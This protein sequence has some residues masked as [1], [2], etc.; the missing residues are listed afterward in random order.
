MR[1][2]LSA[3]LVRSALGAAGFFAV[4][5]NF[6]VAATSLEADQ[7]DKLQVNESDTN[8]RQ[9]FEITGIV[10]D[11]ALGIKRVEQH[12]TGDVL[13]ITASL[14]LANSRHTGGLHYNVCPEH[15]VDQI[16][17]GIKRQ[18]IWKAGT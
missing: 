14:G 3:L 11:S 13:Y 2:G 6:A 10:A 12:T 9:C 15:H 7:V 5:T 17:F 16:V 1:T 8:G 4:S 18:Q